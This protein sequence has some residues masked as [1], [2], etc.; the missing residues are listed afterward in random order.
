M[1]QL[2]LTTPHRSDAEGRAEMSDAWYAQP[3][4]ATLSFDLDDHEVLVLREHHEWAER[5]ADDAG[6]QAEA[7]YHR[8][9]ARMFG[10]YLKQMKSA[11]GSL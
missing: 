1:L 6:E 5:D 10:E 7:R 2:L 8:E 11:G 4:R 3:I 9:R